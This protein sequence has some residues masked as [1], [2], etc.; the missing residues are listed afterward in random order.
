MVMMVLA[1]PFFP[2]TSFSKPVYNGKIV[3]A[4]MPPHSI[5]VRKGIIIIMLQATRSSINNSFI[6]ISIV[7]FSEDK[8][9]SG[10]F[11]IVL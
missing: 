6:D 4:N 3:M 7:F 8:L 5:G 2:F 9:L 11:F 10:R 1:R